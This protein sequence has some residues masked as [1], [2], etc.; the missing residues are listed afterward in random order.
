MWTYLFIITYLNVTTSFHVIDNKNPPEEFYATT[1][2]GFWTMPVLILLKMC[3]LTFQ[4][5]LCQPCPFPL[6]QML[7]LIARINPVFVQE[8]AVFDERRLF[9]KLQ[10]QPFKNCKKWRLANKKWR[11][12]LDNFS[13]PYLNIINQRLK[14]PHLFIKWVVQM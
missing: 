7:H 14:Y 1:A 10:D 2:P 6:Q 11:G 5:M 9:K 4:K 3:L 13:F 12:N 8:I